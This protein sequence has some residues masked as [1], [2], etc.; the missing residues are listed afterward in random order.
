M[1]FPNKKQISQEISPI[2][3][4]EGVRDNSTS[5]EKVAVVENMPEHIDDPMIGKS[6]ADGL[7]GFIY[8]TNVIVVF[9]NE[10][11]EKLCENMPE[12]LS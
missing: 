3:D 12:L 1:C 9:V 10:E 7:L 4:E 5:S 11:A 8:E 6:V 2:Y